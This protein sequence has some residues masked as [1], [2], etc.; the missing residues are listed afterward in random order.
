MM[1][2]HTT[3]RRIEEESRS[4]GIR[5]WKRVE[6]SGVLNGAP[7]LLP[8]AFGKRSLWEGTS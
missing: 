6:E 3:I 4:G 8:V 5:D 2:S 1:L 7:E